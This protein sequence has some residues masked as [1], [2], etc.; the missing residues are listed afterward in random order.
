[1][2]LQV[3]DELV[4]EVPDGREEE[5]AAVIR[6]VM[7]SA[8]EP[9][10]DAR[11]AA[12]RRGRLGRAL[13]RRALT[14]AERASP[15]QPTPPD[16]DMAALARGG[17]INFFGFVLRLVGAPAVPVHRR[18]HLR[19]R[20]ARPLRLCGADRRVRRAARDARAE[21]RP[22][23]AARQRRQAACL[24]RRRRAA[25]RRDRLGDRDGDPVRLSA[26]DVPEQPDPRAWT[27]C[28]RSP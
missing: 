3:H 13:G 28:C 18:P 6:Q 5:A 23:A 19:R 25:G 27:G 10:H 26:G 4:F 8:A 7:A 21:A 1:M 14:D 20:S 9:A 11:R 15:R 12:G 16:A 24:R 2:L 17:R 22:G